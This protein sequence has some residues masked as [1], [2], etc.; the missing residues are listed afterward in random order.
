MSDLL[1]AA[2]RYASQARP[3]F[4]CEPR[5]KQ[6]LVGHGLLDATTALGVIE[7]WWARWPD[8]NVAIRT[9]GVSRLVVLDVDGQEGLE[10][11]RVLERHRGELPRTASVVTPRGGQHFYF[12]H[13]GTS[14]IPCSAGKLGVGL[15]VRADGGYVV[16]PPSVGST[17]RR[18]EPDETSA[19]AP[20]PPWLHERIAHE[21]G[22]RKP[23]AP[24]IEWLAIARDGVDEGARDVQLARLVGHLLRRYV[25]VDLVAEVAHLVN[26]HRFRPPLDRCEVDKVVDSIA[27][28]EARRRRGGPR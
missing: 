10:S 9:G 8:A 16:A 2:L 12:V 22:D 7:R 19:L 20:L 17:T 3:V 14:E 26:E 4:P 1:E 27:S 15:D 28:R 21:A 6:P 5:G 18:Y 23:A 24:A 25:D 13:P 11:L